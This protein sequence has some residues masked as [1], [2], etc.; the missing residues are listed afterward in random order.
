LLSGKVDPTGKGVIQ[1]AKERGEGSLCVSEKAGRKF[2]KDA[3]SAFN[4]CGT[5]ARIRFPVGRHTRLEILLPVLIDR[6]K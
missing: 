6:A 1:W 3:N 4:S 5:V 2:Q